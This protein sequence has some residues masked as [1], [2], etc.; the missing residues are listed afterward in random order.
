M[1][2]QS[3][4]E[5]Q[6]LDSTL[7]RIQNNIK[8]AITPITSKEIID[9]RLIE[10][11]VIVS[12]TPKQVNTGLNREPNGWLVARLDANSVV[13]E[14]TSPDPSNILVLNSSANCTINL[15]VF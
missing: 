14:S 3:F 12:G 4:S 10:E 8:S 5:I 9:G 1:P 15:W 13:W 2:L 6:T 11:V 7:N